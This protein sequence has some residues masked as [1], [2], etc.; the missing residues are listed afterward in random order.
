MLFR[1]SHIFPLFGCLGLFFFACKKAPPSSTVSPDNA[2]E[3]LVA[4]EEW[5]ELMGAEM[6][7]QFSAVEKLPLGSQKAFPLTTADDF[8]VSGILTNDSASPVPI[9][10]GITEQRYQFSKTPGDS[11]I[12]WSFLTQPLAKLRE[13]KFAFLKG[14]FLN[15]ER[16]AYQATVRFS[17]K[18]EHADGALAT[19]EASQI[20]TWRLAGGTIPSPANDYL[21]KPA[22][23]QLT[24]WQMTG[25][26]LLTAPAPLFKDV[27]MEAI[28]GEAAQQAIKSPQHGQYLESLFAGKEIPLKSGQGRF[29]TTDATAQHPG[30][31]VVDID[32]D[33]WDDLYVCERFGQ[34]LLFRNRRDG[35]FEEVAKDYGL[36][37]DGM[38]A[39]AIF[40]DF[41]NDGDPDAFIGRSLERSVFLINE[42]GKFVESSHLVDFPLPYLTTSLAAA[43]YNGDGLLDIY[44]CTYGF[45]QRQQR[46]EIAEAFL[47]E[48]S[49]EVLKAKL[50]SP[51]NV[52]QFL[53][54]PGPPNLLLVNKGGGRFERSPHHEQVATWHET[55]QATWADVDDDGYPDLYVCNDFAPDQLYRNEEGKGFRDVTATMGHA[56]MCGFGMG[57]SFGD[58]DNDLDLDLYVSNMYSKAG[59]RIIDQIPIKDERFRWS[60]EGNLLFRNDKKDHQTSF[61]F[62]SGD[63]SPFAAVAQADWSW[64][65]QFCDFN[66]DSFLDIY[67]PNGYFTAPPAVEGE[68]DL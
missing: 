52:Q 5:I 11:K 47:S 25:A 12:P 48:Y 65:G 27:T 26:H 39:C 2:V 62:I 50:I 46:S 3:D 38:S 15:A 17:A 6:N 33:G 42:G 4:S 49:P 32:H 45:A 28:T 36:D 10:D 58:F 59:L 40:A 44:F 1:N 16:V 67:V 61:H 54:L 30:L 31:S 64:G 8:A 19:F 66:N 18:A 68:V 51:P 34:N 21:I 63:N 29:F 7:R 23:W 57:A 56:R 43:D 37:L 24:G 53:N 60:A 13:A 14:A 41:D 35:T 20:L 22:E 9:A 55:L